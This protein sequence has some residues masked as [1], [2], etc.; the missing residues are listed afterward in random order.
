MGGRVFGYRNV[1]V[2]DGV[3]QHGNPRRSHTA[4]EV[5]PVEA[6]VVVRIFELFAEGFGL[7]RIAKR[8]TAEGAPAPKPFIRKDAFGLPPVGAWVPSTVRGV[9]RREDYRGVY[10]W[11]KTRKRD[12]D[13]AVDQRPR[14]PAEWQRT[15]MPEWRMVSDDLWDAVAVRCQEAEGRAVRFSDGRLAGR[16]PRRSPTC[17]RDRRRAAC[18]GADS[19]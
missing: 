8:L 16:P 17:L 18:V 4:R 7:K 5:D 1:H 14:P 15:P 19:S 2:Y 3:D 9:L 10:V 12:S 13:G 11:N 6:A